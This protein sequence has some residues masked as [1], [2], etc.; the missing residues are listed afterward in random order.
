MISELNPSWFLLLSLVGLVILF[1]FGYLKNQSYQLSRNIA[2]LYQLN[3]TVKQDTLNFIDQAWHYLNATG[4]V[5]YRVELNWY[6]SKQTRD[7]GILTEIFDTETVSD[8]EIELC[9]YFYSKTPLKGEKRYFSN[10]LKRAFIQLVE[11]NIQTKINQ[12]LSTQ[13]GLQRTQVFQQH[14]LKNLIQFIALLNTQVN[15]SQTPQQVERL[16]HSLKLSLPSVKQ[17]AERLLQKSSMQTDIMPTNQAH[18]A[19][20]LDTLVKPLFI[21]YQIHGDATVAY[22]ENQLSESLYNVIANF[23]DHNPSQ[24]TLIIE[25]KPDNEY[26]KIRFEQLTSPEKQA[27]L[28]QN[29]TRLFEPFW[30][31]SESGMGLGL[32]IARKTLKQLGGDIAFIPQNQTIGFEVSLPNTTKS[33]TNAI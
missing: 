5:G 33:T 13:A 28:E 26:V 17:R 7:Y 29:A 19:N 8:D 3:K 22:S 1:V 25:I 32:Y 18:L 27:Q 24:N 11:Q 2:A 9:F 4:F 21:P 10:L 6:G 31:N 23:R 16:M 15:T 14:D 20:L 12:V 30:T